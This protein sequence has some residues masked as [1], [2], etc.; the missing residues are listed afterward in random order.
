MQDANIATQT[1]SPNP[2]RSWLGNRV[3]LGITGTTATVA[4]LALG[5]DWLT[6]IGVAPLILTAAPCLV[7]CALAMCMMGKGGQG[8]TGPE[9]QQGPQSTAPPQSSSER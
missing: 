8:S 6:A 9:T 5:W 2:I 7:M 1:A 4:G 3:V